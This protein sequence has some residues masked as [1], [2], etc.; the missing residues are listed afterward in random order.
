[1]SRRRDA[2]FS[3]VEMLVSL[4]IL[5]MVSLMVL[6][7]VGTGRRVW[8][9]LDARAAEGEGVSSAQGLLRARLERAFPSTRFDAS[10]PYADFSGEEKTVEFLAPADEAHGPDALRRYTLGLT[11]AGELVLRSASDL[12]ADPQHPAVQSVVL[13]RGVRNLELGYFGPTLVDSAP[14]WRGLWDSQPTPPELVRI[15]LAFAPGDRRVWP[16]LIVHPAATIDSGCV[17]NA[18]TGRCGGRA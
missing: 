9:T 8:E 4:A 13:L 12:A 18:A 1:M 5:A 11:P 2:G 10:T 16:D 7:G 3:L 15:R 14:R 6:S 17:L